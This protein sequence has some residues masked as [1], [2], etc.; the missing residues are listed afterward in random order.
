MDKTGITMIGLSNSGK[1][2]YLY[3]MYA[4]MAFGVNGFT[5]IPDDFDKGLDLEDQWLKIVEEGKWPDG[6]TESTDYV[7]DCSHSFRRLMSFHWHDYRGNILKDRNDSEQVELFN[8]I[9]Q[10]NSLIFC[11]SAELLIDLLNGSQKAQFE[12]RRYN[13]LLNKYCNINNRTVPISIAITKIDL[14]AHDQSIFINGIKQLKEKYLNSLFNENGNWFVMFVPVTLGEG[15]K[16]QQGGVVTGTIAPKNIHLPVMFAIYATFNELFNQTK[17]TSE[18]LKRSMTSELNKSDWT[19]LWNGD[20]SNYY[21]N[22]LEKNNA[23]LE[24]IGKDLARITA[25]FRDNSCLFFFN[26]RKITV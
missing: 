8:R 4:Q 12:L 2:C 16:K 9:N 7:F 25:E 13:D 24:A 6:T 19:K 17:N 3:A 1:S 11:I 23:N 22:E 15:L 21:R 26:G 5:F 14:I 10:S 20:S 18:E